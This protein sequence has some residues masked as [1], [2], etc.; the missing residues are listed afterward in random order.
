MLSVFSCFVAYLQGFDVH[1]NRSLPEKDSH[2]FY[3]Y[4]EAHTSENLIHPKNGNGIAQ[5]N[6]GRTSTHDAGK[7][8]SAIFL[9]YLCILTFHKFI[10]FLR[11]VKCFIQS[12]NT[13]LAPV[14]IRLALTASRE[15]RKDG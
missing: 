2:D 9:V 8:I 12:N 4:C 15:D 5:R 7:F 1:K 3:F 13:I 11:F 14:Q 10:I 6:F